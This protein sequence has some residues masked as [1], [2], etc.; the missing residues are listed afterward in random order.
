MKRRV[1]VLDMEAQLHPL[2]PSCGHEV[3]E[4]DRACNACAQDK[5]QSCALIR[6]TAMS[7]EACK[8]SSRAESAQKCSAQNT[9]S[10][11]WYLVSA[12]IF[13]L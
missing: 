3:Q 1:A 6:G 8:P 5:A 9:L 11:H 7:F 10:S 2:A 4:L 13:P 12:E